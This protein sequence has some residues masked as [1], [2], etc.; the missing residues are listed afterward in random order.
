MALLTWED[1]LVKIDGESLPGELYDLQ[2]NC[3]VRFDEQKVDGAS[4][5]KRT[6]QGWDDAQ[7]TLTLALITEADGPDCYDHLTAINKIFRGHDGQANPKVYEVA[8][9]H[10]LAR[11]VTTLIFSGLASS[12]TEE[13]D[14]MFAILSFVENNPPV[15]K[16]EK[17]VSKSAFE[18]SKK[19]PA[20]NPAGADGKGA[21]EKVIVVDV[22]GGRP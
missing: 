14:Q 11:G 9:R 10:L 8:N 18:A 2:V 7:V 5:Q 12:E 17:A 20:V 19:P 3:E 1:G 6:P 21:A 13:D 15:V 16:T 22:E 4:G